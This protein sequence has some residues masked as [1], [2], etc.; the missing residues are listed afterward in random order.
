MSGGIRLQHDGVDI[1]M[2]PYTAD[3]GKVTASPSAVQGWVSGDYNQNK[4]TCSECSLTPRDATCL[5]FNSRQ[6]ISNDA[7]LCDDCYNDIKAHLQEHN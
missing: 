6:V 3:S 7:I 1:R 5:M 2:T 4:D